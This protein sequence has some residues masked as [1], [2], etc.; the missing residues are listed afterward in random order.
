MEGKQCS[1][2]L[3]FDMVNPCI[4]LFNPNGLDR[5][6]AFHNT[7]LTIPQFGEFFPL[8][9]LEFSILGM[10]FVTLMCQE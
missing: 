3:K 6:L 1:F 4:V 8:F 10:M 5:L 9:S 7:H 2:W